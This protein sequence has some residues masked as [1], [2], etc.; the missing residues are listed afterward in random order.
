MEVNPAVVA[1]LRVTALSL[2][3]LQAVENLVERLVMNI[4]EH[5]IEIL[6]K[7]HVAIAVN[8][9]TAHDALAAQVQMPIAP[10]VVEC[11]KVKVLLRVF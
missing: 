8:D 7:R 1:V 10:L 4:A 5:N 3:R 11:H 2:A 9:E 6:T